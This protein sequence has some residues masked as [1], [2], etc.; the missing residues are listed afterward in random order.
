MEGRAST[1]RKE[2]YFGSDIE[3]VLGGEDVEEYEEERWNR[4][5]MNTA[6]ADVLMRSINA[7][8]PA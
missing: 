4:R 8:L 7:G 6:K 1:D 3:T 2:D 5:R